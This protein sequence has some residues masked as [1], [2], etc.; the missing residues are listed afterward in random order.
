MAKIPRGYILHK[1]LYW[2]AADRRVKLVLESY[3]EVTAAFH[4]PS[5]SCPSV[6]DQTEGGCLKVMISLG[7]K[8]SENVACVEYLS[9]KRGKNSFVVVQDER[10]TSR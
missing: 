7:L 10:M 6:M 5:W 9:C 8:Q 1:I 4:N 2:H 3:R